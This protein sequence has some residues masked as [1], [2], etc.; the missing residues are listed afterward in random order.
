MNKGILVAIALCLGSS[1]AVAENRA[2]IQHLTADLRL[3]DNSNLTVDMSFDCGS[4]FNQTAMIITSRQGA[5]IL[6]VAY[7]AMYGPAA[8]EAIMAKWNNKTK[9]SDPR[10]PTFIIV[11][12]PTGKT[13]RVKG[14]RRLTSA[15]EASS[16]KTGTNDI[17]YD[18]IHS[19]CGSSNHPV[20]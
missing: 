6:A 15:V 5:E 10:L 11:T 9:S 19:T 1:C 2:K 12:P 16:L 7:E 20:Y 8:G 14:E 3:P 13:Y 17:P 4:K 18:E